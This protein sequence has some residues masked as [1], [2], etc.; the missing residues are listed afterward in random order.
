M[1]AYLDNASI[2]DCL[3]INWDACR[4]YVLSR[5]TIDGGFCF[6]RVYG[7]EESNALDAYSAVVALGCMKT[8]I[9]RQD[10]LAAWLQAQQNPCG[11]YAGLPTAW[12][13]LEALRL[14][15]LD[16]TYAPHRFL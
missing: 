8:T 3:P 6:Y 9:P 15:D 5:Q 11:D 13:V 10:D 2:T 1:P 7:V 4:Q 12:Y 14:L 16:P